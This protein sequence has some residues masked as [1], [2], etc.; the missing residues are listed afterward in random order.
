[1]LGDGA[2]PH[3]GTVDRWFQD[4]KQELKDHR[5]CAAFYVRCVLQGMPG[6]Y[7]TGNADYVTEN[8]HKGGITYGGN[9]GIPKQGTARSLY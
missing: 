1:M 6:G 9:M 3:A 4:K 2:G 7:G 8:K 5:Q